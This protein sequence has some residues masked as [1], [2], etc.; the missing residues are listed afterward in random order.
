MLVSCICHTWSS[1]SVVRALQEGQHAAGANVRLVEADQLEPDP[2]LETF[3]RQMLKPAWSGW[4]AGQDRQTDV[5]Q[6]RSSEFTFVLQPLIY[7]CKPKILYDMPG[8]PVLLKQRYSDE[9]AFS[10]G[11]PRK[12]E[13]WHQKHFHPPKNDNA[14]VKKAHCAAGAVYAAS[15][16]SSW[17]QQSDN[18][19][20]LLPSSTLL[21]P[22]AFG[23]RV[24]SV[25]LVQPVLMDTFKKGC[26]S[27]YKSLFQK[28]EDI[29]LNLQEHVNLTCLQLVLPF[30][31]LYT[32]FNWIECREPVNQRIECYPLPYIMSAWLSELERIFRLIP[33][34]YKNRKRD[35]RRCHKWTDRCPELLEPT[36]IDPRSPNTGVIPLTVRL[37][38]MHEFLLEAT[39]ETLHAQAWSTMDPQG[40]KGA[41]DV[42]IKDVFSAL[43]GGDACLDK[44]QACCQL[45]DPV[46]HPRVDTTSKPQTQDN[47][48]KVFRAL[49]KDAL[50]GLDKIKNIDGTDEALDAFFALIVPLAANQVRRRLNHSD[51]RL[52]PTC[53]SLCTRRHTS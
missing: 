27:L 49:Y 17:Q 46:G 15:A 36:L 5:L 24:L 51:L 33:S 41:S 29:A 48:V 9:E 44:L 28:G 20:P 32:S 43:G 37:K 16:F 3:I 23:Q 39:M 45:L 31:P 47:R 4:E 35:A 2:M 30:R 34:R 19:P 7:K 38:K 14:S 10:L 26:P 1:Q 25:G 12:L 21:E 53:I 50:K 13:M 52:S 6:R 8:L 42:A 40:G 11:D 18:P 22:D